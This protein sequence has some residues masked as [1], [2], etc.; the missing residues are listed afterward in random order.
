M[1]FDE[2]NIQGMTVEPTAFVRI[3]MIEVSGSEDGI[4]TWKAEYDAECVLMRCTEAEITADAY[5]AEREDTLVRNEFM[6][7]SPAAAVNGRL[8]VS[9]AVPLRQDCVFITA[10]GSACADKAEISGMKMNLSG[11]AKLSVVTAGNGEFFFDE[12]N[13][14]V[15]YTC[16][17]LDKTDGGG[18]TVGRTSVDVCDIT[19]RADGNTLNLTAELFISAA[20]LTEHGEDAA[21][22][23]SPSEDAG[24]NIPAGR[25]KI[26]V[27]I[28]DRGESAWDVEKKFRLGC[29]AV[30]EGEAYVI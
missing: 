4:F 19:A 24:R 11:S 7:C 30:R 27:Y 16:E 15:K 1:S 26:R 13:V 14:P 17:A 21:V 10:W 12:V 18:D 2:R 3:V 9:A 8:T 23:L 25:N 6:V 29:D 28:P 5:L 20:L 22:T